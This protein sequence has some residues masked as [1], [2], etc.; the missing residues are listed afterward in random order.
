VPHWKSQSQ[1]KELE[2]ATVNL[3]ENENI[4]IPII[5]SKSQE[6]LDRGSVEYKY[7]DDSKT[8]SRHKTHS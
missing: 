4:S 7:S 6:F 3:R 1:M 8:V 2:P 5:P